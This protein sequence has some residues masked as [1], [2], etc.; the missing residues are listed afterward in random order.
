VGIRRADYATHIYAQKLA[1]TSPTSGG[2][3]VGIVSLRTKATELVSFKGIIYIAPYYALPPNLLHSIIF[4]PNILLT[5]LIS[6]TLSPCS[7]LKVTDQHSHPYKTKGKICISY[8]LT[9]TF[10][11]GDEKLNV[12]V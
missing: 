11:T 7:P 8:I 5:S 1:L 9:F 10:W 2:C 12:L 6:N 4:G 3:L